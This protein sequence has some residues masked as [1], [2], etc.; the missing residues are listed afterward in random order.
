MDKKIFKQTFDIIARNNGFIPAF[1]SWYK[2]NDKVILVLELQKSNY[3]ELFY[4]NIKIYIQMIWGDK[5]VVNKDLIKKSI[6]NISERPPQEFNDIFDLENSFSI[7]NRVSK[8]NDFFDNYLIPFINSS[9][10][11]EGLINLEQSGKIFLTPAV[12]ERILEIVSH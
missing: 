11:I 3:S 2:L 6:G 10:S 12:K 5:Y 1:G 4:L 9:L 7:E 8:L